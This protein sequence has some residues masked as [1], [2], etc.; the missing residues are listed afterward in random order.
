MTAMSHIGRSFGIEFDSF[1]RRLRQWPFDGF[2]IF[3]HAVRASRIDD[4]NIR[5]DAH[6]QE[7][8]SGDVFIDFAQRQTT[9]FIAADEQSLA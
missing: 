8:H 5:A 9:S 1:T 6:E 7:M 2:S 3:A 4:P